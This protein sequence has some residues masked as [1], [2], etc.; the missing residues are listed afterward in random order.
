MRTFDEAGSR[1]PI[2][3]EP[4]IEY[5]RL[6]IS[7]GGTKWAFVPFAPEKHRAIAPDGIVGG[8]SNEYRFELHRDDGTVLIVT[9]YWEPVA[10]EPGEARWHERWRTATSR[11]LEPGWNWSGDEIPSHKRAYEA[12]IP[13]A[14]GEFWVVRAGPSRRV[15]GCMEDPLED[16]RRARDN[17]CWR[18]DVILDIFGAD[19]RYLG[20]VPTFD[21]FRPTLGRLFVRDPDYRPTLGKL[22]ARDD[23][24]IAVVEDDTGTYMVKRYRL[25]LPGE[26]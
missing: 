25:V 16:Y 7:V 20:E 17:P 4:D 8:A 3:W 13:A 1:D 10:V 21:G 18:A 14:T 19:G 12:L 6:S 15:D 2:L 24:L 23:M 26:R 9:R 11:E 22:F 5:R